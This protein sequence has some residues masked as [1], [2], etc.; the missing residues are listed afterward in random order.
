MASKEIFMT[1][2]NKPNL[3]TFNGKTRIYMQQGIVHG[4][5][6]L[7]VWNPKAGEYQMPITGKPW[8]ARKTERYSFG[9]MERMQKTFE[10]FEAARN[11]LQQNSQPLV[12]Q[13][14]GTISKGFS[15]SETFATCSPGRTF[16]NL[17]E[18]FKRRRYPKL[19]RG[20]KAHYDQLLRLHFV[21]LMNISIKS[22]TPKVVDEWIDYLIENAGRF[23]QAVHRKSFSK[24]LTLLG[25]ILHY[26]DEHE[27]D[28][29]FRFPIKAR[30]RKAVELRKDGGIEDRDLSYEEFLKV[31][32][33]FDSLKSKNAATLKVMFIL[34][35][36]QALRI[37]EA[38]ALHW[39][40]LK[41]DFRNPQTSH[42]RIC[43]HMEW[44]RTTGTDSMLSLGFKNSKGSQ[45]F[46]DQPLFPESFHALKKLHFIGAKG[47]VF[48]AESGSFFEYRCI[49]AI[50]AQA[51]KKAGVEY[52]GTHQM[53]H[54]GCRLI[55]NRTADLAV[56][57]QILG[58]RDAETIAVY[59]KRDRSALNDVAQKEWD[60]VTCGGAQPGGGEA[61]TF[62]H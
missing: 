32:E 49:Q 20:T 1:N 55:Y 31:A 6:K 2:R 37:S 17:V 14:V 18:E 25:V 27:D 47:L 34:Q 48:R 4:L 60:A 52:K 15:G 38:A 39:E 61:K 30:H 7:L 12:V 57:G 3:K 40:D 58:N 46:K 28:A 42:V 41:L 36:R 9:V 23:H 22:M 11:W 16:E 10:T 59:A 62:S 13:Q 5:S 21:P 33:A 43:R 24:E 26:Y 19:S 29:E 53:R 44:S 56:A 50:F 45:G 8:V 54:G 51:F 35:F